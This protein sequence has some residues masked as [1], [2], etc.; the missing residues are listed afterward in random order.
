MNRVTCAA[1][2][3]SEP[4]A[5]S[6]C[7]ACGAALG[8]ARTV[9]DLAPVGASGQPPATPPTSTVP[10]APASAA[11]SPAHVSPAAR[12]AQSAQNRAAAA[13]FVPAGTLIDG[14]YS[15]VRLLGQG[16]MGV[17]YLARDIHTDV[18]VVLKAVRSELAHRPDVRQRTLAEGRVLAQIDHPNVVHLKAVVVDDKSLWLV[19]QYIEGESLDRTIERHVEQKTQ[20]PL[21]EALRLFRQIAS[22]IA[23]AHAE[24][25]IHRD[26]KPAN[27]LLRKKDRVAK[28]TDF[29]IAKAQHEDST[30]RVQTRGVIGSVWYMS[31]EQVTGRRDLDERVDI[32]ALG[33]VLFQMLTGRVPFDG[34]SD[35]EIMRAQAE[36]PLPLAAQARPDLPPSID[37]LLRKLCAKKR[38]DRFASCADV[39]AALDR[40][41]ADLAAPA[42][43]AP[44][45]ASRTAPPVAAQTPPNDAT[46]PDAAPSPGASR[47]LTAPPV[48]STRDLGPSLPR[49]SDRPSAPS[50]T[51]PEKPARRLGAWVALG[52]VVAAAGSVATLVVAGVL[53]PPSK[54]MGAPAPPRGSATS[55]PPAV[56]TATATVT[57]TAT[58]SATATAAPPPSAFDALVGTWVG[59]GERTLEA[60]KVADAI[61]LRVKDPAQ[62]APAPYE[63]GEARIVL[64]R[65]PGQESVFAVEDRL[66]PD[67]PV[68]YP[69]HPERARGTCQDIRTELGGAPLRATVDGGRLSVELVKIEPGRPNFVFEKGQTISCVGLSKLPASKVVS[70][71]TKR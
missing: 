12:P 60:V 34:E 68:A 69:F 22:G 59:N 2:G 24:G 67:P 55:E 38:E 53:P 32:Y 25:V 4:A 5:A 20:M 30:G 17:V 65:V 13:A 23:A 66:R 35:Y 71:L 58:A 45:P 8:V 18:D 49:A 41:E 15:I 51:P 28:V 62:F 63:A 70:V 42:V 7:G 31:P 64:R 43:A 44:P 40:I 11:V 6:R 21:G 29:G 37:A 27:V 54:W 61:E 48:A 52:L 39:L 3:S 56:P 16:G 47:D 33:V 10:G 36:E 19:M 50:A 46:S 9:D 14:K 26:L 57:A 1:C